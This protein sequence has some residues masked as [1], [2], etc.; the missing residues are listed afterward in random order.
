MAVAVACVRFFIQHTGM[1]GD[2]PAVMEFAVQQRS[3]ARIA[4]TNQSVT[5]GSRVRGYQLMQ[6]RRGEFKREKI[7]F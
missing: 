7:W 2:E 4:S 1:G 5:E 6:M 3:L